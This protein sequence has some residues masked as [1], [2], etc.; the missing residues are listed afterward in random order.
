[1]L[2]KVICVIGPQ[3]CYRGQVWIILPVVPENRNVYVISCV[4]QEL[5]ITQE[6]SI[7]EQVYLD[8]V[9]RLSDHIIE[10]G[11]FRPVGSHQ[12]MM[13]GYLHHA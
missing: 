10:L 9:I 11:G 5:C 7:D 12:L 6:V 3:T 2:Q 13:N 1:M 8:K 4:Y